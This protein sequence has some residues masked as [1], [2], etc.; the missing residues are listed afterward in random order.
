[1]IILGIFLLLAWAFVFYYF[2]WLKGKKSIFMSRGSG[3]YVVATWGDDANPGT[4]AAPWRTIQ[5]ALE[6]IRPGERLVIREGVYNE[7][8]TFKKSGTGDKPFVISAYQGEKVIL[9]GRGLGWQYGLNFE[10]GVSHIRLTGLVLK[11]F[12]GAGIALWGANNSL[13]LKG[14]DIFDCGEALHIVSAEN[15]QVGESYFHNNAGGGLV[16]S[17]GPLDKAGFSNVRSSYNEGPGRANGFTVESGREILFDRCAADHNSGSGFKGQALNTSMAA[18]VA[19]KNKYNGIEWHGEECRMVNCVVDGNGMAGINLGSSGSYALINNLVIRCGIPGGD[20]GLKVAA[21]AGSLLDFYSNGVVPEKNPAS[22][23]ARISLANNIFA[24]NYGGVRFGSAAIIEREEHNL[25]WS[26]EDAEITAGQRSYSRS[27]LA[28]GTWLKETG[29]GRHSFAGDPLFIDHERGDYRLA[30]NSPAIDRGTGDGAPQ[31]DFSGNVRP[32]GKGFDI[33]PYE[34]A[35]GG[36][37]P[38]QAFIA[39]LPL[40]ASEISGSLKFRV[41]WLAAGNGREVAGF[42]IQVKDGTGGNWQDWLADTGENSRLFVGVDG[43]TYYF[44]VRA[45]DILGNWGEWSEP[46]CMIAPLDDQSDLIRYAGEWS[47][48]KDENAYLETVHYAH[49]GNAS[50]SIN[51]YGSAVAWIAGTGPDRGR[52]V[53]FIDGKSKTTVDLYGSTHRHRMTVFAADLPEG[54]HTMRIEATGDKNGESDGCRID[55][56]GIAIKN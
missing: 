12:A 54:A 47:F 31:T 15:L 55:L 4:L 28:A 25:Y 50:A 2:F 51:F 35:E 27:D 41:G 13:E 5:H 23:E 17:P 21:G 22:G 18:C 30:R 32:Q 6:E 11:N 42:N 48:I 44:R 8:V 39:A 52:A 49:S 3:E 37:L 33:G 43:R 40:Y 9:D 36:I 19:R 53:V 26:R 46:V 16:V 38:P 56:D 45:K 20:Y 14:L 1:M 34:E 10:F 7:N 29:K 24:Y